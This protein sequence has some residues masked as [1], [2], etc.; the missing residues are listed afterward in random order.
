MKMLK[1]GKHEL[2]TPAVCGSVIGSN[3]KA[4]QAG[5]AKAVERG[6]DLIE[7]RIDGL[8]DPAGCGEL[9]HEV[10]TILTNRPEREGGGFKGREEKRV[11]VLLEGIARG[12]ACIDLEYSTPKRLREEVVARAKERNV[13][14]LMSHHD[15]SST[16]S[17]GKLMN[18]ANRLAS[19]GCNLVKV[20]TF[21][22]RAG[23][24]LRVLDFLVQVQDEIS[25]PVVAFAMGDAGRFSRIAAPILGSPIVYA[26]VG[27]AT[28]PGQLDIKTTGK[29]IHGLM[30]EEG[31]V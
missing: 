11:E 18:L 6:A 23:D 7:L 21:A 24:A 9:L 27:K 3:I 1:L 14:T 31:G 19:S 2:R 10:P 28:A 12:V 15:F 20:V 29:L 17:V 30:P 22:E 16:P 26:G 4:M 25:V 13:S 5:V 8:R